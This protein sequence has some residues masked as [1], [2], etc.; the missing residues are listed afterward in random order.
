MCLVICR[1]YKE[2]KEAELL[3]PHLTIDRRRSIDLGH[4][5]IGRLDIGIHHSE[6]HKGWRHDDEFHKKK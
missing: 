2:C 5:G 3:S 1:L 4:I 6:V